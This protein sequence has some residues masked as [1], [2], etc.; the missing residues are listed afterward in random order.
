MPATHTVDRNRRSV[1]AKLAN[2]WT[3]SLHRDMPFLA[4][5]GTPWEV[6]HW[7]VGAPDGSSFMCGA[8]NLAEALAFMRRCSA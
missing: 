7:N 6:G 8:R 4:N 5:E 3:V 1:T 2:G